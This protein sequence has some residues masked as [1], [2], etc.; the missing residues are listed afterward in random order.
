VD[1]AQAYFVMPA[2]P[3]GPWPKQDTIELLPVP[4]AVS[5]ARKRLREMLWEWKLD[6]LAEEAEL[7]VSEL[8]SNAIEATRVTSDPPATASHSPGQPSIAA[9]APA[10]ITPSTTN[11]PAVTA[12]GPAGPTASGATIALAMF[13]DPDRLLV[14]VRDG[15]LCP[16]IMATADDGDE[17]GRGLVIVDALATDWHWYHPPRPHAGKVVW[18][19]ITPPEGTGMHPCTCGFVAAEAN[20]LSDHLAEMIAPEDD[21]DASGV[22]HAEVAREPGSSGPHRCLCGHQAATTESLD[23]HLNAAFASVGRDG[24]THCPA[25]PDASPDAA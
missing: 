6:F 22:E 20:G 2:F 8:C 16:P 25:S 3:R 15:V 9:P 4:S 23:S 5:R 12:T 19:L 7:I 10:T 11:A 14:L 17:H 18:A 13:G 24:R 1:S 21:L